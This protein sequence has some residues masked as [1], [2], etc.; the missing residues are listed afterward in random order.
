MRAGGGAFCAGC[1]ARDCRDHCA[2]HADQVAC[3]V[4]VR[5]PWVCS[6]CRKSRYGCSRANRYTY[7]PAVAQKSSDRRRGE[8]R[9]GIDMDPERAEVALA[10]I[11]DAESRGLSPHET[12]V[13]YSAEVGVGR[14]TIYRWAGAGYG[15]LTNVELERKVGFKP[16]KKGAARR[17]ASHS[18][19]RSHDEFEKLPGERKRARTELDSVTGRSADRKAVLTPRN[20]PTHFQLGLLVPAHGCGGVK[21]AIG[22]VREA[23]PER[24]FDRWMRTAPTDNGGG[25]ADEDGIGRLLGESVEGGVLEARLYH[26]DP[27]QSQQRGGCEKNHT[28]MRQILEKGMF[29]FD[30]PAPADMA[31]IMSHVNSNPRA[32]LGGRSPMEMLR[33]VYG[34]GDAQ[35]LLGAFGVREVGRDEL[36]LRPGILDAE[37]A[38]RGEPPLTRPR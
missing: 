4:L 11:R 24:M 5:A 3:G 28:E 20:L 33:F 13:L 30:E 32:S 1:D 25:S 15:G 19:E 38:R 16:R 29:P 10:A 17:P 26:C 14:S 35:A 36:T 37:R 2:A 8:S 7:D 6:G 18:R 22:D 34:D 12:S 23:M 27:R 21:R 31:V 9:R